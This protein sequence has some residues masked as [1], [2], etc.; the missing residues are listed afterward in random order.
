MSLPDYL[1]SSAKD[2]ARQLT[3]STST[4]INTGTFT[5]PQFVA[6]ENQLQTDA[7]NLAT[8]GIG[9]YQPYLTQ[10]QQLTGPGAGTGAGSIA[11]FM[12]P[13]QS[14]VIDETL[15]QYDQTRAGGMQQIADQAQQFGAFGGG[16][17]RQ[18]SEN[19]E[20]A[21]KFNR[22]K[23]FRLEMLGEEETKKICAD[24][25]SKLGASSVKDMG[26]VM[27][28]LKKTHADEIDFAKAGPLIK[29]LLGS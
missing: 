7:I 13:Y 22:E 21:K 24:V 29:E 19:I 10:A 9:G 18:I 20:D 6:G 5:G 11:S 26:K 1:E 2:F 27:G 3:A 28:E 25:I 17:S 15:R 14:G 23:D 8:Q 12:S 16:M 4:P